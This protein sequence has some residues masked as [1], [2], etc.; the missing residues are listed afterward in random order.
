MELFEKLYG[1][2]S[3]SLD[4]E[5]ALSE[6]VKRTRRNKMDIVNVCEHIKRYADSI[7]F[8]AKQVPELNSADHSALV[9]EWKDK[10]LEALHALEDA[11]KYGEM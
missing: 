7:S 8:T 3:L 4:E 11:I 5:L 2:K 10:V 6:S 1:I 9:D